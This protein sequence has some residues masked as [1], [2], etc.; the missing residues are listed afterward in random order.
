MSIPTRKHALLLVLVK[1][2]YRSSPT[3]LTTVRYTNLTLYGIVTQLVEWQ[4]EALQVVGSIPT[5]STKF[6]LVIHL[7]LF[8][9]LLRNIVS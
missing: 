6:L 8:C 3:P 7:S 1:V 4:L 2:L 5:D 9:Y